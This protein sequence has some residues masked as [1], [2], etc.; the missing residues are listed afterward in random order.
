MV[1]GHVQNVRDMKHR[2]SVMPSVRFNFPQPPPV[3][4]VQK[5]RGSRVFESGDGDLERK[6]RER[7]SRTFRPRFDPEEI[8]RLC[9]EVEAELDY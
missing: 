4:V 8:R 3:V 6:R 1:R 9:G 2:T 5:E 7:L